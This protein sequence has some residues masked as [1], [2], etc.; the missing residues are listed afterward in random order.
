MKR[1]Q[2]KCHTDTMSDSKAIT[3]KK[4]KIYH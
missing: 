3:S 2:T 4:G 1:S